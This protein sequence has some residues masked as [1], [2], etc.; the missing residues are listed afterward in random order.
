MELGKKLRKLRKAANMTQ[1]DVANRIV[2]PY[3][4]A[5]VGAW[6]AGRAKPRLDVMTQLA[7]IFGT[8]TSDLLGD[9]STYEPPALSAVEWELVMCFRSTDER[10]RETI[11][12]VARSQRGAT[13]RVQDSMRRGA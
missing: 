10:G 9:D 2:P 13:G 6:E 5:A 4:A 7:A 8:T 12:S 3:S 1:E 11:L